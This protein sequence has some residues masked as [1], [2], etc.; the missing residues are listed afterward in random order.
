MNKLNETYTQERIDRFIN[1]IILHLSYQIYTP[2][3]TNSKISVSEDN[4]NFSAFEKDELNT[5]QK[6]L[7]LLVIANS[8]YDE[9]LLE[10]VGIVNL[11]QKSVYKLSDENDGDLFWEYIFTTKTY[12]LHRWYH[13]LASKLSQRDTPLFRILLICI[14]LGFWQKNVPSEAILWPNKEKINWWELIVN[15][16]DDFSMEK[17]TLFEEHGFW[18]IIWELKKNFEWKRIEEL[19]KDIMD[20]FYTQVGIRKEV[21]IPKASLLVQKII[22]EDRPN[23]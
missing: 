2:N 14:C 5:V 9:Y 16:C 1:D 21:Q 20:T 15:I 18:G 8:E 19:P 10:D 12:C 7:I 17:M 3:S 11:P 4:I 6:T 13:L 23:Q 22:D